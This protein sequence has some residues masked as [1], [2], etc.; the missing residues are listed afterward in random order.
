[1]KDTPY[2]WR[3][4]VLEQISEQPQLRIPAF[5]LSG[6]TDSPFPLVLFLKEP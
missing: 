6:V 1:M 5:S 4:K 3:Q 2:I